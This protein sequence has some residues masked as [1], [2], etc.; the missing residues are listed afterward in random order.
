[1]GACEY[2]IFE[3]ANGQAR[4]SVKSEPLVGCDD[5]DDKGYAAVGDEWLCSSVACGR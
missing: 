2:V 1:M 3:C 4:V 5:A